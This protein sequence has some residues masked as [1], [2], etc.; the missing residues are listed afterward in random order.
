M[1]PQPIDTNVEVDVRDV[2]P[3]AINEAE[4]PRLRQVLKE[5]VREHNFVFKWLKG[6]LLT[7]DCS[8]D[9]TG[10]EDDNGEDGAANPKN[11]DEATK[12]SQRSPQKPKRL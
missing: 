9:G 12:V 6:K 10:D 2:L 8:E 7:E 1:G 3:E 4:L 5:G 11:A